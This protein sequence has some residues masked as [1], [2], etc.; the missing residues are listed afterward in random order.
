MLKHP[1]V[2]ALADM[3]DAPSLKALA[4]E[5][6]KATLDSK[7]DPTDLTEVVAEVYA[8]SNAR[9]NDVR[10]ALINSAKS[11]LGELLSLEIFKDILY[12]NGEFSSELL[13]AVGSE[14][15]D[16]KCV[17]CQCTRQFC[18]H[19]GHHHRPVPICSIPSPP[20]G[21]QHQ[22]APIAYGNPK[23]LQTLSHFGTSGASLRK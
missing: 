1:R 23:L 10:K 13:V 17:S 7:W 9:D 18:N 3:L 4:I 16:P 20:L 6:F 8:T 2:H 5:K 19:C 14:L 15:S 22:T 11:H 21:L 12:A